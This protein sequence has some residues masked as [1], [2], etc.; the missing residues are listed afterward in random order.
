MFGSMKAGSVNTTL[1]F[2]L[3]LVPGV[4]TALFRPLAPT[5]PLAAPPLPKLG[6]VTFPPMNTLKN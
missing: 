3:P 6:L 4:P 1:L 2:G 5:G